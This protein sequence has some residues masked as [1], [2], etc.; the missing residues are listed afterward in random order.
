VND[1][2]V[3]HYPPELFELLVNAIPRL[4]KGKQNVLNFFKGCGVASKLYT[5]IQEIVSTNRESIDKF[6]IVREILTRLN[7]MGDAA[8]RERREVVKRVVQWEDFSSG[9][10]NQRFEAEGYVA[11]IQK[12]VNIKD[13]FT[14]MNQERE[15]AEYENRKKRD[16][17][18]AE[19]QR[20]KTERDRIK[21][22]L[23]AL[24]TETNAHKRGTAL[25]DVLNRLFKS[26]CI[27]IRESFRRVGS[28]GE[29]VIEQIDGV[30]DLDGNVY[31][32]EM[33]WWS[34]PLGVSEVA[35]HLV[36]VFNRDAARGIL[37][38]QS[39]YTDPAVTTC[40]ESLA[41]SVFVLAKLEE[42]VFLLEREGS[43]AELLRA[44]VQGAIVDKNPLV[45]PHKAQS[46]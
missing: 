40:R 31:L 42:I 25:E 39:G 1:Q 38:S 43:L 10:E 15:K 26:Y 24:F 13:S 16:A 30:I 23:F 4:F 18:I 3:H 35:Q 29:G 46:V 22:D 27:L 20:L 14:R 11:K 19:R 5:D 32:V 45:E 8:L 2:F 44:K 37:I 28:A 33:K 41:K 6:K 36:R 12:L 34:E 9:Y 7:D 17:D 21:A